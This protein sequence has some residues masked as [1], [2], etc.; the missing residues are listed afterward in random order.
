[1]AKHARMK[2][3]RVARRAGLV[4]AGVVV[5]LG[6]L[7]MGPAQAASRAP[8]TGSHGGTARIA[9]AAEAWYAA[10]PIDTCSSPLGCA[11]AQVPTSPYPADTLHVGVAGGQETARPY[12]LPD[13]LSLPVGA[14]VTG[15]TMTLPV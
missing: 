1:M 11:A 2:R 13:L 6:W 8:G 9:D 4:L 14:T 5:P 10:S 15:G 3:R 12:V 7:A